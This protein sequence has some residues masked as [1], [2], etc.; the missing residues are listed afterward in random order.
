MK[1]KQ[2]KIP[3]NNININTVIEG[4]GVPLFFIHGWPESFYSW[5]HQ[6]NFFSKLGYKVIVPDIRGYGSSDKP[7]NIADYSMKK[8]TTDLIGILDYLGENKAHIVGHDWGDRK[9]VV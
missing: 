6:I 5:R 7:E 9:S 4:S 1:F 8:I 3:T 2:I